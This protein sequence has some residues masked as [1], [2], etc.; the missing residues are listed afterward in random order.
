MNL[1]LQPH[2]ESFD[3]LQRVYHYSTLSLFGFRTVSDEKLTFQR[4]KCLQE[5]VRT[6]LR[7]PIYKKTL[8]DISTNTKLRT[9]S[10]YIRMNRGLVHWNAEEV[11]KDA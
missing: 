11:R 2:G 4:S 3:Y 7:S 6:E 5:Q 9:V 8:R 1:W 10:A